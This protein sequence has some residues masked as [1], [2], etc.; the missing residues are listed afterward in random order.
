[1]VKCGEPRTLPLSAL[2]PP[3]SKQVL[4]SEPHKSHK[5][6]QPVVTRES[7][8]RA[9]LSSVLVVLPNPYRSP[10][11]RWD[12]RSV[13]FLNKPSPAPLQ[14]PMATPNFYNCLTVPSFVAQ[15][16]QA[17]SGKTDAAAIQR[18]CKS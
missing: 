13:L 14:L 9:W 15:V 4:H 5:A 1:M 18:D 8:A 17:M 7:T 10:A 2:S 6:P 3:H 12:L 16:N 11:A